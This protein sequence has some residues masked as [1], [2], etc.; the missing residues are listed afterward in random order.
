[1]R[2]IQPQEAYEKIKLGKAVMIDVRDEDEVEAFSCD[3]PSAIN[4]PLS[5]IQESNVQ[6][7]SDKEII[8]ICLSGMRSAMAMSIV[9]TGGRSD[10]SSVE[11]GI[12]VW[13]EYGLPVK[14]N[15]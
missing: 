4:I 14:R 7:P 3:T 5:T 13:E 6:I 10:I 12:L 11:G 9:S 1:M 15:E 8:F 2:L